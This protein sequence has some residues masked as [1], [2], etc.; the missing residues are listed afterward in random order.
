MKKYLFLAASAAMML[1]S[2]SNDDLINGGNDL[3]PENGIRLSELGAGSQ[4]GRIST[5][6]Q[7]RG[8]KADRLELVARIAPVKTS[9]DYKWS[10][11]GIAFA[12]GN[13]YISWHSN[14]QAK[15]PSNQWGGALD[16]IN[17]NTLKSDP[18]TALQTT[19]TGETVKFNNV[20]ADGSTLYVPLT[21]YNNGAVVGRIAAGSNV[22]D[23]IGIPGSSANSV[24]VEGGQVYAATGYAG[25][26]YSMPADFTKDSEFKA[27]VGY[28]ENFGGKHLDGGYLLRTDD[29]EA[30]LVSIADGTERSLGAPL[31]SSEKYAEA[32]DPAAGDWYGL[33]GEK[34]R[35]YGKHTMKVDGNYIYVGG[36]IGQEGKNG[37]R[38]YDANTAEL[39]WENG[40]NTT[41]VCTDSK[42]V[43]AATGAGLRVYEKFNG[44]DLKLYAYEVENY[45]ENGVAEGYQAGTPAQS[46]NFVA[47]NGDLIFVAC[48]QSGVYVFRLNENA[49][50]K[51]KVPVTLDIPAIGWSK[52]E[53]VDEGENATFTIPTTEPKEEDKDFQG[54]STDPNATTPE[55]KGGDTIEVG[56]DT[57]TTTLYPVWK[58]HEYAVIVKFEA[59]KT[60]EGNISGLPATIKSDSRT[61][62][63]PANPKSDLENKVFAGWSLDPNALS[64]WADIGKWDPILAGT[65]T[66]PGTEK[67]VTL[68]GVWKTKVTGSGEQGEV[69]DEPKEPQGNGGGAGDVEGEVAD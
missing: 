27:V 14:H 6:G 23:T 56:S 52:T 48:G 46:Q 24:Y 33:T 15:V 13:A 69:P 43:Y 67:E 20:V 31:T 30:A 22:M 39:K 10:A 34:A 9:A 37:L 32:Y 49:A 61:I 8:V 66:V 35:H 5:P 11:T 60:A 40:T 50:P 51:V 29:T 41:A 2:C 55:Y 68:Y 65:Y 63:I 53:E 12:G 44:E 42:Y 57:E 64:T 25:G 47:V 38:V 16:V 1:A 36:G 58:D 54:W 17:V 62:T 26:L 4:S 7:T 28:K 59:G 45:D 19:L 21:C 3:A 18:T